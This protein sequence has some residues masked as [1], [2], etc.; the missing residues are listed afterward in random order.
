MEGFTVIGGGKYFPRGWG[1]IYLSEG[2]VG[3]PVVCAECSYPLFK[4]FR[5][6]VGVN[7]FTGVDGEEPSHK[8]PVEGVFIG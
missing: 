7:T 1:Y 6:G 8:Y 2:A 3:L 5:F 4:S